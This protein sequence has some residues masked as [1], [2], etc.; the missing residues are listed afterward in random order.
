MIVQ[1]Q[2]QGTAVVPYSTAFARWQADHQFVVTLPS[3]EEST[4]EEMLDRW[5]HHNLTAGLVDNAER[6][7]AALQLG[8]S[9]AMGR[10]ASDISPWIVVMFIGAGLAATWV[11]IGL[12]LTA[13]ILISAAFVGWI[14]ETVRRNR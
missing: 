9:G 3:P 8:P 6:G 13:T 10:K 5:R 11:G 4:L 14:R 1:E 12:M 2:R 7:P